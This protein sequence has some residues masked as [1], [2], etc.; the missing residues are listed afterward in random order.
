MS[1]WL[2][3]LGAGIIVAVIQ[4]GLRELRGGGTSLL[5]AVLRLLA[6]TIVAALLLDAPAARAKPVAT[7][8]ALDGSASMA[9]GDTLVWHASRRRP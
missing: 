3:A 8:A 2:L 6:V 1:P 5:A 7:W 4:Y 9:R